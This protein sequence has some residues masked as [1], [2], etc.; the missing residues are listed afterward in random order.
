MSAD[1]PDEGDTVIACNGVERKDKATNAK[2]VLR[3]L[4]VVSSSFQARRSA[5]T[6]SP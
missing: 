3:A 5:L 1:S 4:M 2:T 6:M